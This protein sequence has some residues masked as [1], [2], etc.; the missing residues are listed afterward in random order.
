MFVGG[1][2]HLGCRSMTATRPPSRSAIGSIAPISE[3]EL[4]D[5]NSGMF[6]PPRIEKGSVQLPDGYVIDTFRPLANKGNDYLIDR[7]MQRHSNFT[8]IMGVNEQ[9]RAMQEAMAWVPGKPGVADRTREHLVASDQAGIAARKKLL[10][11]A[12]EAVAGQRPV[13]A[14]NGGSSTACGR[15]AR[16]RRSIPSPASGRSMNKS[17]R[18]SSQARIIPSQ[19]SDRGP[20]RRRVAAP[21][22]APPGRPNPS[23]LRKIVVCSKLSTMIHLKIGPENMGRLFGGEAI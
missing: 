22:A 17:C 10:K 8:G 15:S 14:M 12:A 5:L 2:R 9:D 1:G 7:E 18:P 6:F 4:E 21:L 23:F 13:S 3:E 20:L 16:S 19:S 11:L